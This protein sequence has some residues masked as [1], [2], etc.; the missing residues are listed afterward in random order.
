MKY[1][2]IPIGKNE[3]VLIFSSQIIRKFK[4]LRLF[5][6]GSVRRKKRQ[7]ELDGRISHVTDVRFTW[8]PF[9]DIFRMGQT[10]KTFRYY[11]NDP[12]PLKCFIEYEHWVYMKNGTFEKEKF[13]AYLADKLKITTDEAFDACYEI[14]LPSFTHKKNA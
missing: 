4:F 11:S 13:L 12:I 8:L 10:A 1:F 14:M 2:R 9:V 5:P 3:W 6:V 7:S